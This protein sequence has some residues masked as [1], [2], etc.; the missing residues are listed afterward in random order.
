MYCPLKLLAHRTGSWA[1]VVGFGDRRVILTHLGRN[2]VWQAGRLLG[3]VPADE[4]LVPAYNCGSEIDPLIQMGVAVK[5]YRVQRGTQIDLQDIRRRITA[6]TKAVYVTHYFGFA[7]QLKGLKE[8]CAEHN[9]FL[10][11]DCALGLF[12]RQGREPLGSWGDAAIF[13]FRKLL[14]VPDGGAVVIN[15]PKLSGA[16]RLVPPA[17]VPVTVAVLSLMVCSARH[18]GLERPYRLVRSAIQ[19]LRGSCCEVTGGQVKRPGLSKQECYDPRISHWGMS[20]VSRRIISNIDPAEVIEKRR[21]NFRLLL[22]G[23]K[24]AR[25][26]Q[27]LFSELPEGVCPVVFPVLTDKRAELR[28]ELTRRRIEAIEWWAG[29]H[30]AINWGEFPEAVY[31]KTHLLAL[32]VHQGLSEQDMGYIVRCVEQ[33]VAKA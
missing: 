4:V 19:R 6:R 28:A 23:L 15:N 33:A 20:Q 11:E 32:P 3:L 12:S 18:R 7:Q 17:A 21:A 8:L 16:V 31:L 5:A 26:I 2:A 25:E 1:D 30:Q 13:S 29:Y 24:G 22:E 14:P 10:I 27:P 9:I